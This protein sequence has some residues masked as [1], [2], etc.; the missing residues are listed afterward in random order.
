MSK[1]KTNGKKPHYHFR[2]TKPEAKKEGVSSLRYGSI[3][4]FNQ[5][6]EALSERVIKQYRHLGKVIEQGTY[7][8]PAYI[9]VDPTVEDYNFHVQKLILRLC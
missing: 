5:F 3:N 4:N 8:V 6:K 2:R 7:Y 9:A 1:N